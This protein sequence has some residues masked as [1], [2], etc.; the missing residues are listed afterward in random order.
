M[1][2]VNAF[3]QWRFKPGTVAKVRLPITFNI[4]RGVSFDPNRSN[5]FTGTVTAVNIPAHYFTLQGPTG[6]DVILISNA[7]KLTRNSVPA[8]LREISVGD[9]VHGSAR[10]TKGTRRGCYFRFV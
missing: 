4:G 2:A 7:T 5:P 9:Q 8:D 1:Q 6:N 10:V 3:R